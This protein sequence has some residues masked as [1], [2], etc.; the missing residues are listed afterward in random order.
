MNRRGMFLAFVLSACGGPKTEPAR[1][2]EAAGEWKLESASDAPRP[3]IPG[4]AQTFHAIYAG[5]RRFEAEMHRMSGDGLSFEA[6][7]RWRPEEGKMAVHGGLWF[8]VVNRGDASR[9]E[10]LRFARA[11]EAALK[12]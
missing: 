9:E 4:V 2:P 7:Q 10:A 11:L 5:P 6:V 1:P 12:R 8:V 3:A